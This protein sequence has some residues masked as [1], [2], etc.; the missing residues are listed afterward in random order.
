MTD[1][2]TE[3]ACAALLDQA[4]R[5]A[6]SEG[7][8]RRMAAQAGRAAGFS[9]GETELLI[10][11][12]PAD[13]AALLWRRHDAR[14]LTLLGDLDPQGLKVRERIARAVE[15]RL[16]A[17]AGDE[18][19]TRRCVGWL[20]LPQNFALGAQLAWESAD[21]LWRWAGDRSTDEN[22]YSKR[23]ILAGVLSAALA[24]RLSA[25]RGAAL[26]FTG[27]RIDEVMR[28]ERWKAARG[29]GPTAL[30]TSAAAALGR[31]RYGRSA[32]DERLGD[33]ATPPPPP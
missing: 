21:G 3:T 15:A 26:R 5:L 6:P 13:L 22:H 31:L 18:A 14:A 29:A 33:A 9:A 25:G 19:V 4:I 10:P 12:G 17:A 11:R 28:F 7:W 30:L 27:R 2:W 32:P 20:A 1:A 16:D 24:V 8:T 23:A